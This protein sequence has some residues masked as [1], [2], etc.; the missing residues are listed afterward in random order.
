M[1]AAK[2]AGLGLVTMIAAG[3]GAAEPAPEPAADAAPD[4]LQFAVTG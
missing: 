4:P 3:C 1:N 2:L